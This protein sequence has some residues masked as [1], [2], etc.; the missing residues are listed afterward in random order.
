MK[1]CSKC[2]LVKPLSEFVNDYRLKS[3]KGSKCLVCVSNY[4]KDLR[5]SGKIKSLTYEQ[6]RKQ[7]EQSSAWSKSNRQKKRQ[8]Y[9][10][11]AIRNP[12]KVKN[13]NHE[14]RTLIKNQKFLVTTKELQKLYKSPCFVCGS[15]D[16]IQIDHIVP[17]SK[18]GRHSIGNLQPLCKQ[19]NLAKSNKF[20]IV[21][22]RDH[23]L[24]TLS[25]RKTWHCL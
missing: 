3:G 17:I 4:H 1:T 18:G 11:W 7:A 22:R 23:N 14:R 19:C 21:F 2:L 20:L 10:Q 12:E 25:E 24:H 15:N 6:K 16:E 13:R 9:K 8:S 5:S